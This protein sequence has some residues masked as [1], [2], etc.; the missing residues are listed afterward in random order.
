MT[1]DNTITED[2]LDVMH[3]LHKDPKTSQRNIAKKSG[4]SIGKV[5]YCLKALTDIGFVKVIN[6]KNSKHKLH[7][8]YILTPKGIKQ[9]TTITKQF[10]AKKQQEFD[11][12]NSY[13]NK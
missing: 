12:L 8:A 2:E 9:K 10:L 5:N 4:F 13:I 7:Y 3:L 6:F 11:K 1:T